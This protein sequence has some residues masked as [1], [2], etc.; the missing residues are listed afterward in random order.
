MDRLAAF[1]HWGDKQSYEQAVLIVQN[2]DI[3]WDLLYEWAKN[4]GAD[5]SVIDEL[6]SIVPS[7][8]ETARKLIGVLPQN[9][10]HDTLRENR[11]LR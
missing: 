1:V 6:K 5:S 2:N 7:K 10:D 11:I 9:L 4:E 3:E 8:R